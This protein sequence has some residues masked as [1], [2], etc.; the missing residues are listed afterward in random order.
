LLFRSLVD[1]SD[2]WVLW[3]VYPDTGLALT[4]PDF[5]ERS[6]RWVDIGDSPLS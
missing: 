6:Y 3:S 5:I 2:Y 4:A 1:Q